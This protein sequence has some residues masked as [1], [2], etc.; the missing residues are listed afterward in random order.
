M[1]HAG[2]THYGNPPEK[3]LTEK[4]TLKSPLLAARSYRPLSEARDKVGHQWAEF[5]SAIECK[6]TQQGVTKKR[7]AIS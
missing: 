2:C 7:F 5:N 1:R 3:M 6:L 4:Q